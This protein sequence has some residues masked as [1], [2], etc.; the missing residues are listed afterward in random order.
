MEAIINFTGP[1]SEGTAD[2]PTGESIFADCI[3]ELVLAGDTI[4]RFGPLVTA[5]IGTD[6]WDVDYWVIDCNPGSLDGLYFYPDGPVPPPQWVIDDM[7]AD[8]YRRTPVVAFNPITS[9][10]G[11]E[12]ISLIVHVP[13]YLWVDNAAWNTPVSA[14]ASIPGGFSVTTSAIPRLATWSGGEAELDCDE[15]DMV[16]YD[17]IRGEEN[18][19]SNCVTFY[20]YSSAT[21]THSI[22]LAVTW[23]VG[24]TCSTGTCGGPLPDLTTRSTREVIVAEIQAVAAPNP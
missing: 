24:Y 7:I 10:D 3:V 9:P 21:D 8:A 20:R 23:T 1:G 13:T 4:T 18:Q 17:P 15:D 2:I 6:I 5:N 14:T 22:D 11:D 12:A 19:L 16:P